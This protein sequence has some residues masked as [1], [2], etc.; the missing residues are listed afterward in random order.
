M[1][2]SDTKAAINFYTQHKHG[3]PANGQVNGGISDLRS[4][5][6][7]R[8]F[9]QVQQ[10]GRRLTGVGNG[11]SVLEH[12]R[13]YEHGEISDLRSSG[14]VLPFGQMKPVGRRLTGV[15]KGSSALE[16]HRTCEG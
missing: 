11:G 1:M 10:A 4:P 2:Q 7:V 13:S 15:G 16:H 5:G 14:V 3:I 12:H 6:V 8:P 9:G